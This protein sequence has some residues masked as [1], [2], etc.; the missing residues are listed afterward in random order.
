MELLNHVFL[1]VLRKKQNTQL[2][3]I[4][5]T[6]IYT[7][8]GVPTPVRVLYRPVAAS[9]LSVPFSLAWLVPKVRNPLKLL[10]L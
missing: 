8:Q 2:Q 4:E 3:K 9:P 10:R 7:L 5:H 1:P 6:T